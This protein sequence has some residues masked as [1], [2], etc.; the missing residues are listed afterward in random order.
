M[1]H[2]IGLDNIM[3]ESDYPHSDSNYPASRQKLEGVLASGPDNEARKIAE[4][5]ARK[6]FNFPR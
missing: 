1:R 4:L 6:V 3:F 5:N 2:L